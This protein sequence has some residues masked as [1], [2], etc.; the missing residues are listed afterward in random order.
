MTSQDSFQSRVTIHAGGRQAVIHRLDALG[1]FKAIGTN[2]TT[3]GM[4]LDRASASIPQ[5]I[6]GSSGTSS[7]LYV[8]DLNTNAIATLASLS[9]V[10]V[11]KVFPS[12]EVSTLRRAAGTWEIALHFAGEAGNGYAVGL[13][14]SGIR[15]GVSLPGGRRV[16][17]NVDN[18]TS[19][20][21]NG[22]L[23][24]LFAGAVG[25]LNS[26]DRG[27]AVLDVSS[28]PVLKGIPVWAVALTLNPQAPLGIQTISDPIRIEL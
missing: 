10:T 12:R 3:Y 7:G 26:F 17:L 23:G 11:Q 1:T 28:L 25:A 4:H 6:F 13:S 15:P 14:L 20:S 21:V 2:I 18:L 8:F 5:L 22:Q 19:L 16:P 9:G 24:P 27:M